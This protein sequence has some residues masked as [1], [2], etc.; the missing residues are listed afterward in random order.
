M[1]D[2]SPWV[3]DVTAEQ[4]E[5][6]VIR[7]SAEVPVIVDFWAPWCQPC[8]ALGPLIEKVVNE[9]GGRVLLAK[10]DIDKSPELAQMMQIE[11]IPVVAVFADGQPV[12]HFMGVLPEDKLREWVGRLVPSK[13]E[14]LIKEALEAEETDQATAEQKLREA[15]EL[16]QKDETKIHLARVLLAQSRDEDCGAVI[17]ELEA[18]GFLEPEAQ[19]I[20]AQLEM[21]AVAEESGGILE[22]RAAVEAN[23]DD[24]S[25]QIALADALAVDGNHREAMDILLA[26]VEK[27]R[28]SEDA[29]KARAQMV[30]IFGVLGDGSALVGE[31]RR[32][33][34]TALY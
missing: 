22:A 13:A 33:L 31:Y 25:R 24:A 8:Q 21:R 32:K 17:A 1:P 16:E 23:P 34:A 19:T 27:D 18:R 11:S 5:E 26:I 10:V 29:E 7:K 4:F 2:Q 9:A 30:K 15:L 28:G 3:F 12:D 20:K 6:Q 14:E